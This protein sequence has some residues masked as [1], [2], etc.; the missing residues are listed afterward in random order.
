MSIEKWLLVFLA[1]GIASVGAI[2]GTLDAVVV[3]ATRIAEPADRIPADISVVFADE[4]GARDANDM[5]AALSLVPGVE[6]TPV[7]RVRCLRSGDFMSSMRSCSSLT[8]Y[9]GAA[10]SI[11]R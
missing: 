11:R 8:A 5:A 3:T 1:A 4:L 6:A 9:R 7:R 2:A 10:P